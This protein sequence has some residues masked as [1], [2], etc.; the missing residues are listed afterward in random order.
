M[1]DNAIR[2]M[3]VIKVYFHPL[4]VKAIEKQE[5]PSQRTTVSQYVVTVGRC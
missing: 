5:T 1:R 3:T 4:V 2:P